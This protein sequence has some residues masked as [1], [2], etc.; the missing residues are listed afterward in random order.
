[1]VLQGLDDEGLHTRAVVVREG[2]PAAEQ[3]LRELQL[4]N[5]YN[6]TVL[7]VKRDDKTI[8]NPAGDFKLHAGDRLVMVG[9]AERFAECA[10]LFRVSQGG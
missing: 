3:T 5:K 7:A 8:G 1:M 6:L 9:L 4:R 10:E 2:A